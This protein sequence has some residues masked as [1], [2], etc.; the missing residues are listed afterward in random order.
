MLAGGRLYRLTGK[1]AAHEAEA[2]ENRHKHAVY[3][4]F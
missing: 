1:W 4:L 2:L 3:S